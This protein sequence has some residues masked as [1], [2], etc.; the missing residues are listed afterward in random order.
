[1]RVIQSKFRQME[2]FVTSL[3]LS[4]FASPH[5]ATTHLPSLNN[6]AIVLNTKQYT[7][8]CSQAMEFLHCGHCIQATML[9]SE[10]KTT[11]PRQ[12][13][14]QSVRKALWF[15]IFHL[16]SATID[17]QVFTATV[18]AED[19]NQSQEATGQPHVVQCG[20]RVGSGR[21]NKTGSN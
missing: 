16:F 18:S 20:C 8:L 1:M 13:R 15:S 10:W 9:F 5:P 7:P 21:R 12:L 14:S 17:I 2:A 11:L 3:A 6:R 19:P 4:S